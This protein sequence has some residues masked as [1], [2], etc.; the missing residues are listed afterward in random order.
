MYSGASNL[1]KST[2]DAFMLILVISAIFFFGITATI[3]YFI[4]RYNRKKH[5]VAE[6]IHGS[7]ALEIAWTVIPLI[8]VTIMFYYGWTGYSPA[9]KAPKD[10]MKIKAIARMW[11]WVFEYENGVKTDTLYVPVDKAVLVDLI[12]VDVVHSLYIPAF[13][14]KEDMVPGRTNRM[15][16]IGQK[17]GSYELF[18]AE[19]CGLSHSYMFT[20]VKVLEPKAFDAWMAQRTDTTATATAS[21]NPGE[22]GRKITQTYGC[23]ACHSN[24]GS[25][26]VGPSFKG[27]Y[28]ATHAVVTGSETRQVSVDD[29]YI[30]RS[31]YEPDADVVQG[32]T[33][34]QMVSYKGQ[35]TDQEVQQI[36]EY[37]KTLK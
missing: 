12:S 16:F 27:I 23:V 8:L 36:I 2:D 35:V 13:R 10:A 22:A 25:K 21:A 26:L 30:T 11:S 14:V 3:I 9:S 34:G 4:V 6:P 7:N 5:P 29:E 37:I 15:W 20:E 19:Y 28:G 32:Y 18:C 33:K 17:T 31:I 1:V 24:D